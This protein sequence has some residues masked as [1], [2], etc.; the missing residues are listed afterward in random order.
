MIEGGFQPRVFRLYVQGSFCKILCKGH[1]EMEANPS[2]PLTSTSPA[3]PSPAQCRKWV[4]R[5]DAER[6]SVGDVMSHL[7]ESCRLML[8][9][10]DLA[11][12]LAAV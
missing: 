9:S 12:H 10:V 1:F 2:S 3:Q 8:G 7:S 11:P 6:A 5:A 4:L